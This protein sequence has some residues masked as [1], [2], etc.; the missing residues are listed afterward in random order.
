MTHR[1]HAGI[2]TALVA[3]SALAGCRSGL[4]ELPVC[5]PGTRREGGRP[6]KFRAAYCEA[7]DGRREGPIIGYASGGWKQWEGAY[8]GGV[9]D[10]RFVGYRRDGSTVG[11]FEL[12]AGSGDFKAWYESGK[13]EEEGRYENGRK[14]GLFTKWYENGRKAAQGRYTAGA[15]EGRFELWSPSGALAQIATFEGGRYHGL[16]TTFDERGAPLEEVEYVHGSRVRVRTFE[17]GTLVAERSVT[18]PGKL[19]RAGEPES[20]T[21]I[22][23]RSHPL[24]PRTAQACTADA[25]CDLVA[26]RCCACGARDYVSVAKSHASEARAAIA[27]DLDCRAQRCAEEPCHSSIARCS[28]GRCVSAQ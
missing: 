7:P 24:V 18:P 11:A 27:R 2:A 26:T 14:H 19:G 1:L 10:G 20:S 23:T 21:T 9:L 28:E 12:R 13:L 8:R 22:V 17:R 16:V 25:D 5:P 3:M 15:E 6:P 4:G